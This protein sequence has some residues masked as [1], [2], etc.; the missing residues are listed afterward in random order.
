MLFYW[1]ELKK[2]DITGFMNIHWTEDSF[3][4]E[5]F[6]L[7]FINTF[8]GWTPGMDEEKE[9]LENFGEFLSWLKYAQTTDRE[10]TG[11]EISFGEVDPDLQDRIMCDVRKLR[12]NLFEVFHAF[13]NNR[14][15]EMCHMAA[16]YEKLAAS[17]MFVEPLDRPKD[18]VGPDNHV[19][20]LKPGGLLYPI[21]HSAAR[22]L[23]E[24][25]LCHIK[26]CS[27]QTCEWIFLDCSKS[28]RRRWCDM[29]SCGNR[30]KARRHYQ[31]KCQSVA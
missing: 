27:D 9:R 13:A 28:H 3:V 11:W 29:K 16:I 31:K 15:P 24:D 8:N 12:K 25:C 23:V 6:C 17:L 20:I 21:A 30:A 5:R 26:E 22:L 4:G 14:Q 19:R 2:Q 18:L 1:L 10:E 7:D